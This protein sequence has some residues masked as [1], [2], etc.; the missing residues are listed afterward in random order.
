[1][2]LACPSATYTFCLSAYLTTMIRTCLMAMSCMSVMAQ[3]VGLTSLNCAEIF[4]SFTLLF[5]F[6]AKT[7]SCW[8]S[9]P[10]GMRSLRLLIYTKWAS[11]LKRRTRKWPGTYALYQKT[12]YALRTLQGFQRQSHLWPVLSKSSSSTLHRQ[13]KEA[14]ARLATAPCLPG[15]DLSGKWSKTEASQ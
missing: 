4:S 1:M 9:K 13:R 8:R 3:R 11:S 7:R 10:G 6:C 5:A 14:L 12:T 15:K 2:R